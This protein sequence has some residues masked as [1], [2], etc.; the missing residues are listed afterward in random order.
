MHRRMY[1]FLLLAKIFL[2]K[3]LLNYRI[4]YGKLLGN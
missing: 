2:E 4:V 1:G 3:K